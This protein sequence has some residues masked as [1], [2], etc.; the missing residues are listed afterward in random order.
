M[1]TTG[2]EYVIR[3]LIERGVRRVAGMPGGAILPLYDALA[4]SELAHVLV[5]HEQAAGFIA[6]GAAR[7]SGTPQVCFATSGPGAT[8]LLT[9]LADAK[10]DSVPVVAITGQVPTALIGTDAFQEVDIVTA[11]KPLVKHAELVRSAT[12]LPAALDRAFEL[13][14][15]GRP[16]PAL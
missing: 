9:A 4:R 5:R 11:A 13:A 10:M 14:M 15:S 6:Q 1:E 3:F 8:N 12:E 2:A 16:G 7:A